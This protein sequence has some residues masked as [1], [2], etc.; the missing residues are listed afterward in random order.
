MLLALLGLSLPA[1]AGREP[2]PKRV[3]AMRQMRD[4]KLKVGD[5][6]PDPAVVA[7]DGAERTLLAD[8]GD[9]P[10][11]VVFGSFT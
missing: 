3:E 10:L 4:G 2:N 7:L 5:K 1:E 8:R 9:K 11:V 6:A